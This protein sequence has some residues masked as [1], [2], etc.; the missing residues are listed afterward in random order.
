MSMQSFRKTFRLWWQKPKRTSDL[1]DERSVTFLEL[2]YD[3]VYV[4]VIAEL[5]HAFAVNFTIQGLLI[6]L[7]LFALIWWAWVNG[8][9]YHDLHGNND[10]R[11]RVFTF[12]QMASV[13]GMSVFAHNAL[14]DGYMGFA[15]SYGFFLAILTYLW[16]RTGVHDPLHKPLSDPYAAS[17]LVVTILFFLSAFSSPEMALSIWAFGIGIT[18]LLPMILLGLAIKKKAALEEYERSMRVRPSMV[19]RFG[20]LT[21]IVLG[22]VVVATVQGIASQTFTGDVGIVGGLGLMIAISMWWLYFDFVS[23]RMPIQKNIQR[24]SWMY[25]HLPMTMSIAVMGAGVLHAIEHHTSILTFTERGIML[26]SLIV[27]L[28]TIVFLIKTIHILPRHKKIHNGGKRL[29]I[30]SAAIFVIFLFIPLKAIPLLVW[31]AALLLVPV[32][33]AFKLWVRRMVIEENEID[34]A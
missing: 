18:L 22:E 26:G 12:L 30:I 3:L 14:T 10:I 9:L 28:F 15:F 4:V 23:R 24:F 21:I 5:T 17:F 25:L 13:V 29:M 11:T 6:F 7:F 16:W 31:S 1:E 32:F 27:F 20:L 19:E 8:S 33:G 34:I 2:F